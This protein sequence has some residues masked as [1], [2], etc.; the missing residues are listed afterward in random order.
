[1]YPVPILIWSSDFTK[2]EGSLQYSQNFIMI[3]PIVFTILQYKSVPSNA[4]L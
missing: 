4:T 2:D 3:H 1:M